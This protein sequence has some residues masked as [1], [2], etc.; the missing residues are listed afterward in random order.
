MYANFWYNQP[1]LRVSLLRFKV[2]VWETLWMFT[3]TWKFVWHEKLTTKKGAFK[4][5][6]SPLLFWT[7]FWVTLNTSRFAVIC[8]KLI[9]NFTL[10]SKGLEGS[11]VSFHFHAMDNSQHFYENFGVFAL[12]YRWNF[13]VQYFVVQTLPNSCSNAR[14]TTLLAAISLIKF[15]LLSVNCKTTTVFAVI[16]KTRLACPF[17][18]YKVEDVRLF[19]ITA[20]C[21]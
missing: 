7:T 14:Q 20:F 19:R 10:L 5:V 6:I 13:I 16:W 3:L 4:R 21:D 17:I 2:N 8:Y 12:K 11:A 9:W 1:C 15:W 18:R